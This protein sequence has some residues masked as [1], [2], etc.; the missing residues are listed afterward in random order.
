MNLRMEEGILLLYNP[1]SFYHNQDNLFLEKQNFLFAVVHKMENAGFE[2][3]SVDNIGVHYSQTIK[4][5]YDHW[6][7]NEEAITRQHKRAPGCAPA[8]DF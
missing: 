8:G 1:S 6:R 7:R 4:L 3:Q 5:W 2:V